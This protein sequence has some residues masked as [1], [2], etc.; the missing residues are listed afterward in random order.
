MI[1]G[2]FRISVS[3]MF[4]PNNRE[5]KMNSWW[6]NLAMRNKLQIPTQLA[7]LVVLTFAQVWVMKQFE[8]KMFHSAAQSAQS[9][10]MQSFLT[11]NSMMLNGS[12]TD[13]A[14]RATFLKKMSS[15]DDVVDFHL[16]RTKAINDAFGAGLPEENVSDALDQMAISTNKMQTEIQN[17]GNYSIRVVVPLPAGAN[18][19]GTNCMQCHVVPENTVT[20][21]VSLTVNLA[22]EVAALHRLNLMLWGGQIALQ[23]FLF[24]LI[25]WLIRNVTD[26]AHELEKTMLVIKSSGDLSKRAPI[27]SGDE[28]GRIAGVFNALVENFQ[29][30]VREVDGH[31][32]QVS[33]AASQLTVGAQQVASNS[34]RQ[35]DAATNTATAVE[36]MTVSITSVADATQEVAQLSQESLVR[37]NNGQQNLQQ[38]IGEINRVESAVKQMA[39]SVGEFVKSSQSITSMT[40]QVR[41]I[42]EQTNLLA[43]NAAIEAAR[44]GE[45][46]RGFAVVADEVRKLAEKSAQSAS[47]ID[48]VTKALGEQS[49]QVERSVQSGLQSLQTSQAHIQSVA[50][51]LAQS[52]ESVNGVNAG[53]DNITSSVNEQK[54]AS[55]EIARNVENIAE[56]A[57]DNNIAVQRTVQSV[58]EMERLADA[59]KSSVGR[60]KV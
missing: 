7:L 46:G 48:K 4:H 29:Q 6:Y 10:A 31:A 13:T 25:G 45:Q 2:T 9:S 16:V 49:T 24:F 32:V 14:N 19:H 1:D 33:S 50:T 28:I 8:Q 43:L 53:V 58:Q 12:I 40:Q 44:A 41:D 23:V 42:A 59:L 21:A 56:M 47:E 22:T 18:F 34:Q 35:S 37:A 52:N 15:Q 30:I 5:F 60:F 51:V 39:E 57:D 38:M 17:D 20:G 36:E 55:Q 11:L 27:Y 54:L 26:P 3:L